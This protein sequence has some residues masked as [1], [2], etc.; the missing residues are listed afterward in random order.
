MDAA[1]NGTALR[2]VAN[3]HCRHRQVIPAQ[4]GAWMHRVRRLPGM[5][6]TLQ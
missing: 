3:G 5:S 4:I 6:E 1:V 2:G